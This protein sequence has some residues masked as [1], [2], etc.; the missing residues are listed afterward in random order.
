[1]THRN[2]SSEVRHYILNALIFI[3]S[4]VQ[5]LLP[6]PPHTH[7]TRLTVHQ[8]HNSDLKHDIK[9]FAAFGRCSALLKAKRTQA[10]VIGQA[11]KI[12]ARICVTYRSSL[13]VTQK[14]KPNN[15][16][17]ISSHVNPRTVAWRF[18][19]WRGIFKNS[20]FIRRANE[21][22][23]LLGYYWAWIASYRRFGTT[24]QS[25]LQGSRFR[26]NKS[27]LSSLPLKKELIDCLETLVTNSSRCVTS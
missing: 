15:L 12:C 2:C 4:T 26:D 13:T 22:L 1:M 8:P 10:L 9:L 11:V 24:Y 16:T 7:T 14:I 23:P 3:S 27:V 17:S 20:G 5:G 18:V 21:T 25:F 19:D 6:P